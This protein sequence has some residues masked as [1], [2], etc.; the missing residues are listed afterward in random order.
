MQEENLKI[1]YPSR[2]SSFHF[3]LATKLHE[4]LENSGKSVDLMDSARVRDVYEKSLAESTLLIVNPWECAYEIGDR[5]RLF[6]RMREAKRRI[7]VLAEAVEIEWFKRQFRLPLSYDAVIDIGFVSQQEKLKSDF[8]VP[9]FFLYNAPTLE[10]KQALERGI[11]DERPIP[12][13]FVGHFRQER[14]RLAAKLIQGLNPRGVVFLPKGGVVKEG[15]GTIG[16]L[17]L[18]ALL[19]KTK[20]YVW[21]SHHEFPYYESLRFIEALTVGCVPCKVDAATAH[22]WRGAGIPGVFTSVEELGEAIK[23]KGFGVLLEEARE[24]Y[25]SKGLLRDHLTELFDSLGL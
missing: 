11:N 13:A 24:Y 25:L 17:G 4:T 18:S 15:Q 21:S 23:N 8:D 9:Y 22:L 14:A 19:S 5:K 16:P 3:R 20:F 7:A 2:G 1:V 12:W 10:E 6:K